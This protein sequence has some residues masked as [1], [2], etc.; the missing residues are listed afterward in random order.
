MKID[1]G[2]GEYQSRG[3]YCRDMENESEGESEMRKA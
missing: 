2:F 1:V 3:G